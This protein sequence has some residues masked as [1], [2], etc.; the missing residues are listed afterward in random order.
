MAILGELCV[1]MKGLIEIKCKSLE[2]ALEPLDDEV[3]YF[4][5]TICHYMDAF[6]DAIFREYSIGDV[7]DEKRKFLEL[8][9]A[10]QKAWFHN[11]KWK[12]N[13]RDTLIKVIQTICVEDFFDYR[14]QTYKYYYCIAG[15]GWNEVIGFHWYA[16]NYGLRDRYHKKGEV[17]FP[18]EYLPYYYYRS[19]KPSTSSFDREL[20]VIF[21]SNHGKTLAEMINNL[22]NSPWFPNS[23]SCFKSHSLSFTYIEGYDIDFLRHEFDVEELIRK[24]R[25]KSYRAAFLK[26][27]TEWIPTDYEIFP[28]S[29]KEREILATISTLFQKFIT[30]DGVHPIDK[31]Y[32]PPTPYAIMKDV[33]SKNPI[34]RRPMTSEDDGC[35]IISP[36]RNQ[37]LNIVEL[38]LEI[39]KTED[40]SWIQK[41][42]FLDRL[43][44][45]GK[46]LTSLP[47]GIIPHQSLKKLNLRD[48]RIFSMKYKILFENLW[49][50]GYEEEIESFT[51]TYFMLES[52][53]LDDVQAHLAR[54]EAID[55]SSH[56]PSCLIEQKDQI[57]QLCENYENDAS[58]ELQS[59]LAHKFVQNEII[60]PEEYEAL[61]TLLQRFDFE[62]PVYNRKQSFF[63]NGTLEGEKLYIV[64]DKHFVTEISL[65][66][67]EL[68]EVPPEISHFKLLST[69]VLSNNFI[70]ELP[71]WMIDFHKLDY[72]WCENNQ[73]SLFPFVITFLNLNGWKQY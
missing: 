33:Q 27:T 60:H 28:I 51:N 9:L 18:V 35:F 1:K 54:N 69:L 12:T 66:N 41:L 48:T 34:P 57:L 6:I 61:R 21:Q 3:D 11:S 30:I 31:Y 29:P 5:V 56:I 50:E 38:S 73:F 68:I 19:E 40:F 25:Q 52:L 32:R 59:L 43:I 15:G 20:N 72:F 71:L 65:D 44:L 62:I 16:S 7:N 55:I 24:N 4:F 37:G 8:Y 63:H 45:S 2:E 67:C 26:K 10:E 53:T 23:L 70:T 39:N 14:S 22:C 47:N 36:I 17:Y 58:R 64:I 13:L 49:G 42:L 46:T